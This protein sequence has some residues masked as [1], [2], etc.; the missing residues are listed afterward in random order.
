M[1]DI[2]PGEKRRLG[3]PVGGQWPILKM[4]SCWASIGILRFQFSR[5]GCSE[6]TLNSL[7]EQ[8]PS[9]HFFLLLIL[10][11]ICPQGLPGLGV[12]IFPVH[13]KWVIGKCTFLGNNTV[14]ATW[15]LLVQVCGAKT[16]FTVIGQVFFYLFSAKFSFGNTTPQKL[17]GLL[18]YAF[19]LISCTND[20]QPKFFLRYIS[21]HPPLNASFS[22]PNEVVLRSYET[23]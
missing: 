5:E 12:L 8:S 23:I 1:Q 17:I 11:L 19:K 9:P 13:M 14:F 16:S 10:F 20:P 18:S 15:S 2:I 4:D 22:Q 21:L 7:S 6:Q 3:G